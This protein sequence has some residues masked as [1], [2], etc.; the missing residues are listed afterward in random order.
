[1]TPAE[2]AG[3][4]LT[5][6]IDVGAGCQAVIDAADLSNE[7]DFTHAESCSDLLVQI[8]GELRRRALVSPHA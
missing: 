7:S 3:M 4:S 1:M 5:D 2:L 6:L 8:E